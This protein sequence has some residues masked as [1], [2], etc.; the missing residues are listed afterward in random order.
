MEGIL[1]SA[2]GRSLSADKCILDPKLWNGTLKYFAAQT[3]AKRGLA[4]NPAVILQSL[5]SFAGFLAV[6]YGTYRCRDGVRI[7]WWR[8]QGL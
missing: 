5:F 2:L 3:T 8:S 1:Q 7:L 6:F 4:S